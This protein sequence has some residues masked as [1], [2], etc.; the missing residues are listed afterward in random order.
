[1]FILKEESEAVVHPSEQGHW[2][3]LS[4]HASVLMMPR[5]LMNMLSQVL[6]V[7]KA[8]GNGDK[9]Y[10]TNEA[11]LEINLK[12]CLEKERHQIMA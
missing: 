10:Q 12:I 8:G 3:F 7:N 6:V 2:D 4:Q 9:C 5:Q 11:P 1:M